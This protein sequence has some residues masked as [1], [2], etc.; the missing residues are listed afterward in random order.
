MDSIRRTVKQL[1]HIMRL[2]TAVFY[3]PHNELSF[4]DG[5]VGHVKSN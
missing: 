4:V 2:L 5:E 3:A 1:T